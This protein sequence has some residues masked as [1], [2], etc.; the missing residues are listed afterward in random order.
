MRSSP[1]HYIRTLALF[2]ID[3][4]LL[5]PSSAAACEVDPR[6][7][8]LIWYFLGSMSESRLRCPAFVCFA[9]MSA[10]APSDVDHVFDGPIWLDDPDRLAGL[11]RV[12]R[13]LEQCQ[14][15]H[16]NGRLGN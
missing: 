10:I 4:S 9:S 5:W 15:P 11:L 2:R 8:T 7:S 16:E 13:E 3:V 6:E 1:T 12:I 14:T